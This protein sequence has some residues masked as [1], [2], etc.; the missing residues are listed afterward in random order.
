MWYQDWESINPNISQ[1]G[2]YLAQLLDFLEGEG[3][4]DYDDVHLLGHS[5][6]A[7]IAGIAGYQSSG[8]VGRITGMDPARPDFEAP[9]L[10]DLR[11]RLD[12]TDAKFVDVIHTCAGTVGFTRPIGHVDFYPNGGSFRQP[13]CPVLLTRKLW[14]IHFLKSAD[15]TIWCV[16]RI[17]QSRKVQW[18]YRRIHSLPGG[19]SGCGV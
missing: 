13:G 19:I 5:L 14:L 15:S 7:H 8:K 4:L 2:T 6:G 3:D 12:S 9:L 17:L 18:V 10:K 11:D 16:F 1:V